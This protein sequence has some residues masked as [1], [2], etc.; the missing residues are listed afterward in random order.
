[1]A[2]EVRPVS[3]LGYLNSRKDSPAKLSFTSIRLRLN[4]SVI[5]QVRAH[6]HLGP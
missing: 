3:R 1:M 2:E 6:L 4:Y 5:A